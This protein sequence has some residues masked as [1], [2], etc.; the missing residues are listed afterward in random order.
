MLEATGYFSYISLLDTLDGNGNKRSLEFVKVLD[1]LVLLGFKP[2][3]LYCSN[4]VLIRNR[5]SEHLL[6][7]VFYLLFVADRSLRH[8]DMTL[9]LFSD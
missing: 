3:T 9:S 5:L 4:L 6:Q 2:F 8:S 7:Q 1:V